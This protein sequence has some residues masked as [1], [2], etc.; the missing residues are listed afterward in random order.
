M[1]KLK[2]GEVRIYMFGGV[3]SLNESLNLDI[4]KEILTLLMG[5]ITQIL[6]LI[7]IYLLYLK[8]YVNPI[9]FNKFYKINIF[10]LK[11][12]LLPILP[13]DGGKLINNIFDYLFSYS[14][15]HIFS[16]IISFIFIPLLFTFDNK[17]FIIMT[18]AFLVLKNIEEIQIHKYKLNKLILERKLHFHSFKKT[19]KIKKLNNIKRNVNF[20]IEVNGF[21]LSERDYFTYERSEH[22]ASII[23]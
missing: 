19:K 4:K 14:T 1:L 15:S 10:L 20:I 9:T 23:K 8:G 17:L 11:F 7:I 16:I 2:M 5:P 13:L 6:F 22:S 3:T 21:S 12:N 18:S